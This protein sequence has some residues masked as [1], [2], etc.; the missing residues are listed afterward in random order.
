MSNQ[1]NQTSNSSINNLPTLE[2]KK[3]VDKLKKTYKLL[4]YS[5]IVA[6]FLASI[7][8][9]VAIVFQN[10]DSDSDLNLSGIM[11]G[12]SAFFLGYT[13]LGFL[14]YFRWVRSRNYYVYQM[15]VRLLDYREFMATSNSEFKGIINSSKLPMKTPISYDD[16][17]VFLTKKISE[18]TIKEFSNGTLF[19]T[20]SANSLNTSKSSIDGFFVVK[21]GVVNSYNPAIEREQIKNLSRE[22]E[23]NLSLEF[24]QNDFYHIIIMFLETAITAENQ[25]QITEFYHNF[26]G[27]VDL[28]QGANAKL[29]SAKIYTYLGINSMTGQLYTF[30]PLTQDYGIPANLENLIEEELLK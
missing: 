14:L 15:M 17:I 27:F 5:I 28:S 6:L 26:Y 20:L 23:T 9:L 4:I 13:V 3:M 18:Y 25:Q 11:F 29:N 10:Q 1:Q 7:C 12:I 21:E 22:I 2:L 24:P 30:L 19:Y 16:I 8:I